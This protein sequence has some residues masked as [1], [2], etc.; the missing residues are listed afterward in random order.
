[1]NSAKFL[2]STLIAAAAMTATA[3]AEDYTV[4]DNSQDL[5]NATTDDTVT[6]NFSSNSNP[7]KAIYFSCSNIII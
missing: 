1:M 2:F 3:Y 4:T 7:P 6:I 5:I